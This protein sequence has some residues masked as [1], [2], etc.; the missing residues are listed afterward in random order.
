MTYNAYGFAELDGWF[1]YPL[2]AVFL[3]L[4]QRSRTD[5]GGWRR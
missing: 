4:K 5:A 2:L 1:E 3:N